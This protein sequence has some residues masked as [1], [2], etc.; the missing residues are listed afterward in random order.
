MQKP[1][2]IIAACIIFPAALQAVAPAAVDMDAYNLVWDSPSLNAGQSMPCGGGDIGLN[3]WVEDGDILFYVSQSGAYDEN[4]CLMKFG[5]IRVTLS[6]NPFQEPAVF[7][8]TLK[9]QE[10]HIEIIGQKDGRSATVNLWVDVRQPVIHVEIDADAPV[11]VEARYESWRTDDRQLASAENNRNRSFIGAPVKALARKDSIAFKGNGI[12]AY[13]RNDNEKPNVFDLCVEQQSLA[14]VKDQLWNPVRN[15]T[16]GGFIHGTHMRPA[17]TRQGRYASADFKSWVLKS[18]MPAVSHAVTVYLHIDQTETLQAWQQGLDRLVEGYDKAGG[19]QRTLAWWDAFWDRS[20]IA[21]RPSAGSDDVPWT[22]GRNYQLFRYQLGCNAYGGY[23]TKF[24]GGL[25]TYDPEYVDET[26]AFAPDYRAWGGGSFT[27]QNQRLVYWPMLKSGDFDMMPAQF[28]FYQRAL[29]NAELRT[30]VY[31]GH[32][33]ASFTEQMESFALPVAFEYGWKRPDYFDPG[34]EYNAWL[35]YQWDTALEFC[36]M[37]LEYRRYGGHDIIRYMP[38]IESCLMFFDEHYRMRS[39]H[40]TTKPLDANG[41]L[42]LYPGTACETY[43]MAT[44][45]VPTVTALRCVIAGLLELPDTCLAEERRDYY[46]GY[47]NRIPPISFREKN[48]YKTIAPAARYERINNV[49]LPQLYPVFPFGVYGIGRPDLQV[50]VDTWKYGADRPDQKNFISW[51]QDAIFCARLGL[52]DEAAAITVNKLGD[53]GRRCPTFWGPGRDWV[54]DHNWGGSGMI[55]LQEMLMQ[56]VDKKIYLLPAWPN[57]W[58]VDFK[59]HAPYETVIE[60]T[61]KSGRIET[62]N[63]SPQSRFSDIEICTGQN[64]ETV[65]LFLKDEK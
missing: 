61:V 36:W 25:F 4:N 41:H 11:S 8:Q 20:Y 19:R 45:A 16:S 50:A 26:L 32:K 60:G 54:P 49:E 22:I 51:H 34:V 29:N 40:R 21:I 5:R 65:D 58:D 9:L 55:G 33:G 23:P 13:H 31:W 2:F 10:G 46:T 12:L 62:L 44:N 14:H 3:V 52:T 6:P 64:K 18:Q 53:S 47:L 63:V 30:K 37:I 59:L 48:G 56:A 1:R 43:K 38:L 24:N 39:L 28:D 27:A 57:E 7:R 35:E 17:G 15:L 42:V